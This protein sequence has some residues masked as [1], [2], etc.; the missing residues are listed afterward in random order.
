MELRGLSPTALF[1]QEVEER[2][3]SLQT[4]LKARRKELD[5]PVTAQGETLAALA[6]LR[7]NIDRTRLILADL[8]QQYA[9]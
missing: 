3:V 8:E 6:V 5:V 9:F 4:Q 2:L 1:E 7:G